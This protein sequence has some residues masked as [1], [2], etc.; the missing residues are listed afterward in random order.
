M[1][2]NFG[3]ITSMRDRKT[4]SSVKLRLGVRN[5]GKGITFVVSKF[6]YILKLFL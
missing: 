1:T 5:A 6:Y 4:P 3:R 2:W